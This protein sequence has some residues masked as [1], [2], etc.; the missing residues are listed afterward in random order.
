MGVRWT[1]DEAHTDNDEV[2]RLYSTVLVGNT[3]E[4]RPLEWNMRTWED[5]ILEW[6]L[7]K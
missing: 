6:I 3:E 4:K 5:N 1:G 7:D 2:D